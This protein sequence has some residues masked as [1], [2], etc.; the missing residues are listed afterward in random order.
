LCCH[1]KCVDNLK[2]GCVIRNTQQINDFKPVQT[3]GN[4][5]YSL[6]SAT[7]IDLD[8]GS[9]CSESFSSFFLTKKFFFFNFFPL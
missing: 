8:I 4:G 2:T 5:R 9:A 1:E 6:N 3:V 7:K